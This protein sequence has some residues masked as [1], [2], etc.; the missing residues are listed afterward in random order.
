MTTITIDAVR[1]Q[2]TEICARPRTYSVLDHMAT[3]DDLCEAFGVGEDDDE[4]ALLLS[5]V[6]HQLVEAGLIA[7]GAIAAASTVY[8]PAGVSLPQEW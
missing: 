1:E 3:L 4:R 8:A 5:L 7:Q 2:V 6:L